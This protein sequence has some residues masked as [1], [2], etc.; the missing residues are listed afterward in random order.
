MAAPGGKSVATDD[1]RR[2]LRSAEEQRR[3]AIL[4]TGRQDHK[5]AARH[6]RA[7]ARVYAQALHAL[8]QAA[9]RG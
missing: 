6:H 1:V 7:S 2:L 3:A 9:A 4:A 8:E 5:S